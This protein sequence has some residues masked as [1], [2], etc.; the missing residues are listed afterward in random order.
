MLWSGVVWEA[1]APPLEL[2]SD[3]SVAYEF[4]TVAAMTA[5]TIV[6][7]IGKKVTVAEN[8][9]TYLVLA[10]T[11]TANA[12]NIKAS[13]SVSQS[14]SLKP[15]DDGKTNSVDAGLI[16]DG[17]TDQKANTET[18]A[19]SMGTDLIIPLSSS[20]FKLSAAP[21]I[22]AK[23][24]H[25]SKFDQVDP[26]ILADMQAM[27]T[28]Q[29]YSGGIP[30]AT[31]FKKWGLDVIAG[32]IKKDALGTADWSFINNVNH[33]TIGFDPSLTY[34]AGATE[35]V[36]P[37]N[38]PNGGTVLSVIAAPDETLALS[39]LTVGAS[40][41]SDQITLKMSYL[42]RFGRTF[43]W[44]GSTFDMTTIYGSTADVGFTATSNKVRI[45]HGLMP[46]KS[47]AL[48]PI[49]SGIP[50]YPSILT[51]LSSSSFDIKFLDL[52]A[53]TL[54]PTFS[55]Q[56]DF[57]L[58]MDS[59]TTMTLNGSYGGASSDVGDEILVANNIWI[60]GITRTI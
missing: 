45:T 51:N 31:Q 27:I 44:N 47:I 37:Y 18:V 55:A 11:G 9:G 14:F 15:T 60:Y 56:H 57:N 5:S 23:T 28:E 43:K 36:L 8:T 21:N 54:D 7:P 26:L 2:A 53:G 24:V 10:G 13:T 6:F 40:V 1:I 17:V 35:L 58:Y 3:L 48:T 30:Q 42:N 59:R 34:T 38:L 29:G 52:V 41:T 16:A 32:V 20:E 50:H 46:S 49:G 39:G 25:M 12:L 22:G 4:P 33:E 19:T